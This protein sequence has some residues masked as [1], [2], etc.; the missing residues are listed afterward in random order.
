MPPTQSAS[1]RVRNSFL[2][3]Q[4]ADQGWKRALAEDAHLRNGLN[5]AA[6]AITHEAVARD[7]GLTLKPAADA[8]A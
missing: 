3:V 5:V 7:L 8:L 4:L 1:V 6:G 2:P